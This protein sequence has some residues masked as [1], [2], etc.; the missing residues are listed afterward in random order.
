M[1][2][3]EEII[4]ILKKSFNT[5][6]TKDERLK[7]VILCIII[8]T[9]FWFFSALNKSD[10]VTQI[11]YPVEV[12]YNDSLYVALSPIPEKIPLEVTGG[13]WD[14]MTRSFGFAMEPLVITLDEPLKDSFRLTNNLR[15]EIV[16]RLEPVNVNY[17]LR[18][19]LIFKLDERHSVRLKIAFDSANVKLT[20]NHKI[21]SQIILSD[22]SV[23]LYGPK[24]MLL[25][26]QEPLL[27]NPGETEFSKSVENNFLL[28][29]FDSPLITSS[30]AEFFVKFDVTEFVKR[31]TDFPVYQI[32]F[33]DKNLDIEPSTVRVSYEVDVNRADALDSTDLTLIAD[34]LNLRNR[35]KTIPVEITLKSPFILNP[36]INQPRVKLKS[37]E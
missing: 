28:P 34:Y 1:K 8:S 23:T 13:G 9:T 6:S 12:V 16:P 17:F 21:T 32:N 35:D 26:I 29:V 14:L 7:V 4:E 30:K 33:K 36:V 20:D 18:D 3:A 22:D 19:S 25:K 27:I 5:P 15:Q 11:N 31:E 10:Y 24:S 2:S 37:N